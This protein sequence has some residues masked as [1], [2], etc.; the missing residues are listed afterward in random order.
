MKKID[1]IPGNVQGDTKN[2]TDYLNNISIAVHGTLFSGTEI[3]IGNSS[4]VIHRNRKSIRFS[5]EK[6]SQEFSESEL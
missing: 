5:L 1:L 2:T 4:K 6:E 3:Q